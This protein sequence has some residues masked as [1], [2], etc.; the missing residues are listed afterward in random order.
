M[1]RENKGVSIRGISGKM[2][3]LS[4]KIAPKDAFLRTLGCVCPEN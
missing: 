3:N 1:K 4:T 2:N